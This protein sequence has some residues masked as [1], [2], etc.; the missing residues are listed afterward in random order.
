M[1]ITVLPHI[2]SPSSLLQCQGVRL[3]Y[4]V[5]AEKMTDMRAE[6]WLTLVQRGEIYISLL[7]IVAIPVQ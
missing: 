3:R 1:R 5:P 7:T 2:T 6:Y 4:L